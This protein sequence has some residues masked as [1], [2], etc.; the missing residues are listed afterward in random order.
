MNKIK[1][2][3]AH[4]M[5]GKFKDELV[6]EE[7]YTRQDLEAAGFEVLD[8]IAEEHIEN[9]HEPLIQLS[10]DQL[11]EYWKRD[12]EMI[13]DADLV[14]DFNSCNKSDGV[15]KEIGYARFCLW[16]PVVRVFPGMGINISK[17][18][19]DI[20][21]NT[22]DEAILAIKEKFGSY[23]KLGMWRMA[24]LNRCLEPWLAEQERIME[25]YQMEDTYYSKVI[26]G[27]NASCK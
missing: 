13:R 2:Y 21:T 8:P 18:E 17:L 7:K 15:N 25:R 14:L 19:D 6:A 24:M 12:K 27:F 9:V 10:Q 1:I 3:V 11:S 23:E 5:T 20:I 22:L 4:A 26:G 16:K